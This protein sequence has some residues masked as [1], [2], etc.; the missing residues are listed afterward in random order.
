MGSLEKKWAQDDNRAMS[1]LLAKAEQL[2]AANDELL[3]TE[4]AS[5]T[6]KLDRA[7]MLAKTVISG[8]QGCCWRSSDVCAFG[9]G[10]WCNAFKHG[11]SRTAVKAAFHD[12]IAA[13]W[14]A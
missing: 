14:L 4:I 2:L 11:V 12:P 3:S 13:Q 6:S 7:V 5:I 8:P 10:C 9:G 1:D